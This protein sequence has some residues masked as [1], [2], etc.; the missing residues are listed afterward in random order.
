VTEVKFGIDHMISVG[1]AA[2]V[3]TLEEQ[4]AWHACSEGR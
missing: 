4:D 2:R 3:I 1:K